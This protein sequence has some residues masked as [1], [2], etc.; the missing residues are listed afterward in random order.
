MLNPELI[1]VSNEYSN[2]EAIKNLINYIYHVPKESSESGTSPVS[3]PY[4]LPL[5]CY[6]CIAFPPSYDSMIKDFYYIRSKQ[7][8]AFVLSQQAWHIVY[9]FGVPSSDF[10][11]IH[12]QFSNAVAA[13]FCMEYQVCYSIHTNTGNLHTH[14]VISTTN[15]LNGNPPLDEQRLYTYIQKIKACSANYFPLELHVEVK[16]DV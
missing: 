1:L 6:G 14:F 5:Y 2:K 9:S 8:L 11:P 7:P 15:Y 16:Y 13:L 3:K 12:Q 4:N 10:S